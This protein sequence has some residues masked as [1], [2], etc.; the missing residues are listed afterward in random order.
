MRYYPLLLDLTN[1]A[2]LVVGA[3]EV[4]LRKIQGL[5]ECDAG[6][7]TVVDPGA[8]GPELSVLLA[9]HPGI[10]YV[11]RPFAEEDLSGQGLVFACTAS[12]TVNAAVSAA[13]RRRG[14]LCNTA[15]APEE[16]S[17]VLPASITRGGLTIS[18][19]T[20]G[21]SP[22]LARVIRQELEERYGPEYEALIRLLAA[23][24]PA[25]L[26]LGHDSSE[27]RLIFRNLA[28]SRLP[29]LIRAKDW[30]ACENLLADLLPAPL[31]PRIGEWCDDCFQTL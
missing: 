16:G 25:L 2:C 14:I 21:A 10:T 12:R 8:P 28:G 29:E 17:F 18:V 3:G 24:R 31:H 5:L 9:S 4:G 26:A 11:Q 13:G 22:A 20:S 6:R 7:I 27:N 30:T 23:I 19:S 15:D 1:I